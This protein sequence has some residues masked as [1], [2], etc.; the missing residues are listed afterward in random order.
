MEL[1]SMQDGGMAVR[2]RMTPSHQSVEHVRAVVR[3]AQ[4]KSRLAPPV[5]E[6]NEEADEYMSNDLTV[7]LDAMV[8]FQTLPHLF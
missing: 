7:R 5:T 8:C 1:R 4:S 2:D 6:F 3:E